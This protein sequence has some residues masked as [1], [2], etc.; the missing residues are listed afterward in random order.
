M[1]TLLTLIKLLSKL[2]VTKNGFNQEYLKYY[3]ALSR[4]T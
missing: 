4:F 1:I 3:L 2:K